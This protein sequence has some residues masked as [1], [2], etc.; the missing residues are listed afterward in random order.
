M[1][2]INLVNNFNN[3]LLLP[4]RN[5]RQTIDAQKTPK[6]WEL[7]KSFEKQITSLNKCFLSAYYMPGTALVPKDLAVNKTDDI[8]KILYLMEFTF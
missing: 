1:Y 3:N 4:I 5:H 8:W 6:P 7:K 2:Y